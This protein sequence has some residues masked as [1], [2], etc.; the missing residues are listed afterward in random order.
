MERI[1]IVGPSG[2]GKSTLCRTLSDKLDIPVIHLDSL[3]FKSGWIEIEKEE[4][5]EK[6]TQIIAVNEKWIIEGNYSPTLPIRL[7]H[8]DQ[9]IFLDYP[10]FLYFFRAVKRS[11]KYYGHTRPDMAEG[12]SERFDFSFFKYVWH[13]P[14]RRGKLVSTLHAYSTDKTNIVILKNTRELK[15]YLD[16]IN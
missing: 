16:T 4:L 7:E 13:F 2:S 6:V 10:R 3:F 12:C 9:A 8:C 15:R 5:I 11:F 14:E 1:V